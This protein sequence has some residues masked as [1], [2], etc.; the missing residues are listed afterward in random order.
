MATITNCTISRKYIHGCQVVPGTALDGSSRPTATITPSSNTGVG[1]EA[2]NPQG[3]DLGLVPPDIGLCL[4]GIAQEVV[5]GEVDH[6]QA[7]VDEQPRLPQAQRPQERHAQQVA[8]EQRRVA[9]RQQAA[10]AVADD[11]DEEDHR[12]LDVLALAIGLQQRPDQQHGRARRADEAGQQRR[13]SPETSVLVRLW[14]CKSPS[15]R[16]PPLIVYRLNNS[17][18]NGTN[19]ASMALA[20]TVPAVADVEAARV[21]KDRS[22]GWGNG[23]RSAARGRTGSTAASA[24][25]SPPAT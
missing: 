1:P 15:R 19:S 12:V 3:T 8:E 14:A 7:A 17:T 23:P 21:G 5:P 22:D 20:N 6:Q 13:R 4:A 2:R 16:M 18:M 25:A 11:E 10:A 9:D 24:T